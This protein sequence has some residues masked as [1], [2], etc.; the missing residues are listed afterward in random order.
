LS[1][2]F[3]LTASLGY[4]SFNP[5]T[6]LFPAPSADLAADPSNNT[7]VKNDTTFNGFYVPSEAINNAS[8]Q[9]LDPVI[10][11][12]K[13]WQ[14]Q[15]G[16]DWKFSRRFSLETGAGLAFHTRAYSEYPIVPNSYVLS[17]PNTKV[18]NSLEGYDVIRKTMA[19]CFAGATYHIG[20]HVALKLQWVHTFQPYLST[21]NNNNVLASFEQRDDF[22][23]G[24]TLGMK[25]SFL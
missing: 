21:E 6:S 15:V 22:I 24:I 9:D 17:S 18:G 3:D 11:S 4:R 2:K 20:K 16:V 10:E 5:G 19:T 14:A 23:R 12:L 1:P 25:Y 8:Y 13:Q 7:L